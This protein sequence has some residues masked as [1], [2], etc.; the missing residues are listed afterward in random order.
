MLPATPEARKTAKRIL[1][2]DD[3]PTHRSLIQVFLAGHGYTFLE[4]SDGRAA[5]RL[6]ETEDIDLV[7]VDLNMPEMDGAMFVQQ[8]R[9]NLSLALRDLPV[10]VLTSERR[11]DKVTEVMSA[12]AD[13]LVRKPVSESD[14]LEVVQSQLHL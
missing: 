14:L 11:A 4:A 8:L 2:V 13:K 1:L 6:C 9:S 5:L 3:S 7:I 12:G 10:V